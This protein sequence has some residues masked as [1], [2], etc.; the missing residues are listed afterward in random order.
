MVV[1]RRKPK[2]GLQRQQHFEAGKQ[3]RCRLH[4]CRWVSWTGWGAVRPMPSG[5]V[6]LWGER[7][8]VSWERE[9]SGWELLD[10]GL[11]VR[12]RVCRGCER[13]GL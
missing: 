6:L 8:S 5:L 4:L 11:S 10:R 7:D 12:C 9:L 3:H 13:G 1:P 2:R